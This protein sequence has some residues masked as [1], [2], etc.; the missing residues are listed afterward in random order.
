MHH[1]RERALTHSGS[2]WLTLALSQAH[3]RTFWLTLTQSGSLWLSRALCGPHPGR[4]ATVYPGLLLL[5][6][7]RLGK[8]N[9]S[10]LVYV[11]GDAN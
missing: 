10:A 8:M 1:S 2:N 7:L 9:R 11:Q 6:V 4:V 5:Q 3:S